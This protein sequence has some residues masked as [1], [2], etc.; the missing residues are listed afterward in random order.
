[1]TDERGPYTAKEIQR[2]VETASTYDTVTESFCR[3]PFMCVR[4]LIGRGT[5]LL[6][7]LALRRNYTGT[8]FSKW[9]PH[10]AGTQYDWSMERGF[11]IA[12]GRAIKDIAEQIAK[13]QAATAHRAADGVPVVELGIPDGVAS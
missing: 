13:E 5:E 1:M 2:A 12:L 4:R 3:R 8:G 10:D 6:P 9:N 11:I 7:G